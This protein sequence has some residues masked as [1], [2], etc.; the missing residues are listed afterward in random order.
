MHALQNI[1]IDLEPEG[2]H[3]LRH[4]LAR[5]FILVAFGVLLVGMFTL[6]TWVTRRIETGVAETSAASAALYINSLLAPHL[7][8]LASRDSLSE[9]SAEALNGAIE[10]IVAKMDVASVKIWNDDGFVIYSTDRSIIGKTFPL[11]PE[12]KRAWGGAIAAEFANSSHDEASARDIDADTPLL[13][14][15]VPVRDAKSGKVIA[16]LEFYDFAEEIE[17]QLS[18]AEWHSWAMTALVTIAMMTALFSIVA[19]GSRT[20]D[21]QRV[22]LTHRV[23]QLSELLKQNE[24]LRSRV[25]RAARNATED[26]EKFIRRL[27]YDLHDGPAQLIGLALLRLDALNLSGHDGDNLATIRGALSDALSDIRNFCAG[28]LLPEVH[29]MTLTGALLHII[30]DHERRTRTKVSCTIADLPPDAPQFMKVC[31]CRFVQE[32]LNNAFRHAGGQGQ[33][34]SAWSDGVSIMV[35][36]ADEGPGMSSDPSYE[37]RIQLGLT[38]LR[39]RIESI[40]GILS[41]A[42]RPGTG[43][44][45]LAS[46]PLNS[47]ESNG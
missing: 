19:N 25:E 12:L 47:G 31:L 44:R 35:E 9:T 40:G 33:Q 5:Q 8:D 23:A 7:Q 36:V 11:T 3:W 41:V 34:V 4:N 18:K 30:R 22:S 46:L 10:S 37:G 29:N 39:D 14:V 6:G 28:L 45:L 21:E 24:A 2:F 1:S 32:A 17:S 20:I 38:G 13:E 42:S 26:N 16:V 43:T 15:Y 27:G